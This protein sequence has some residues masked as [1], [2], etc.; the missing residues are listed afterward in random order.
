MDLNIQDINIQDTSI[1]D[2][3]K[4][5][6]GGQ[7]FERVLTIL[8]EKNWAIAKLLA[9]CDSSSDIIF[10]DRDPEMFKIILNYVRTGC[11]NLDTVD[12]NLV[13]KETDFYCLVSLTRLIDEYHL[14][15]INQTLLKQFDRVMKRMETFGNSPTLVA[16]FCCYYT[17][18]IKPHIDLVKVRYPSLYPFIENL[19]SSED[20]DSFVS[21]FF[22]LYF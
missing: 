10:I 7:F 20:C 12:I 15:Q 21:D 3:V 16:L 11:I 13:R 9:S 22:L 18:I 4:I 6:V 8:K 19:T 17:E 14:K 5:N 2:T 1:A